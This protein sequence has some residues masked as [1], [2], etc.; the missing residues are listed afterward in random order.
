MT[1]PLNHLYDY[2][3]AVIII[4]KLTNRSYLRPPLLRPL[5]PLEE[6]LLL[7]PTED[8]PNEDE[9]LELLVGAE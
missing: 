5:L 6:L 2:I 9:P 3:E 1:A 8:E 7:D 4:Y